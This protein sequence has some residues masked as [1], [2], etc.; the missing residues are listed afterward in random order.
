MKWN[1]FILLWQIGAE[2]YK[3]KG[4]EK[5]KI[6]YNKCKNNIELTTRRHKRNTSAK[7]K[8]YKDKDNE[9]EKKQ[10]PDEKSFLQQYKKIRNKT[11]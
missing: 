3:C 8:N 2:N 1:S 9:E 11:I 5:A 10:H 7:M 4:T 6:K